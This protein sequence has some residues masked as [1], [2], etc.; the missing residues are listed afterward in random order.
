MKIFTLF[1][2]LLALITSVVQAAP[3]HDHDEA[4]D[5]EEQIAGPQGGR[6]L[7]NENLSLEILIY[8]QGVPPEMRVYAYEQGKP[9]EPQLIKLTVTLERL[10]GEQNLIDFTPETDYLVGDS[11]IAEPHSFD[12]EVNAEYQ[13]QTYHWHFDSFEGR[14]M[15][16]N[17]MIT[18]SGIETEVAGPQ[19]LSITNTLYGVVSAAEDRQYRLH[20]PY[21]GIIESV[22]VNTG[23]KVK[24]GQVLVKVRNQA[25]LQSYTVTSPA[26]GEI[27]QRMANPGDHSNMGNLLEITDLSQVWVELSMFPADIEQLRVGMPLTVKDLHQHESAQGK[28]SYISPQMTGGHIAR[29][30]AEISNAQGHWRPGMH[31][32]ADVSVEQYAAPLAVKHSAIQYYRDRPV[33]FVQY[34]NTFEVRMLTLGKKGQDYIEVV[35]GL[36][37]GSAYVITNSFLLKA[38]VLKSG[39]S[40]HH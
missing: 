7:D 28:I 30:R 2:G 18:L 27:T 1:I 22:L 34:G 38:E 13:G 23:D 36:K 40:H 5:H 15:I 32:T 8:E 17:R 26:N 14:S 19:N 24:K 29:A 16:P 11:V 3:G 39:A 4:H 20:A 35:S 33:V 37:P 31:I 10:D 21:P 25:T 6:L 9:V 12:V